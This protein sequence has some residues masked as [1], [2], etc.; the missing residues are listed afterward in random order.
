MG[1]YISIEH[2]DVPGIGM[3]A[4]VDGETEVASINDC[5]QLC[6]LN[7]HG[8][9]HRT[10]TFCN[11]FEWRFELNPPACYLNEV[12]D[13]TSFDSS[14]SGNLFCKKEGACPMGYTYMEDDDVPGYGM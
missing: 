5:A 10:V 4:S 12:A 1:G 2:G 11:S 3:T 8:D 9:G 6:L 13:P 14:I 7:Q